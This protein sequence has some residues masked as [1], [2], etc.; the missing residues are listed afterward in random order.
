MNVKTSKNHDE[1]YQIM[2]KNYDNCRENVKYLKMA[3]KPNFK[4]RKYRE[5]TGYFHNLEI[6]LSSFKQAYTRSQK[7]P[8][9]DTLAKIVSSF[10]HYLD[11][12]I[13]KHL[14]VDSLFEAPSKFKERFPKSKISE[15]YKERNLRTEFYIE[16]F[17]RIYYTVFN[18]HEEAYYG[19]FKIFEKNGTYSARLLKGLQSENDEQIKE[20]RGLFQKNNPEKISETF[21]A[22]TNKNELTKKKT[23]EACHLYE[24]DHKKIKITSECITIEFESTDQC[25]IFM[26]WNTEISN[27]YSGLNSYIGGS[28]ML[29]ETNNGK[30]GKVIAS[31]KAGLEQPENLK[32]ALRDKGHSTDKKDKNPEETP[33]NIESM[34]LIDILSLESKN[35]WQVLDNADDSLWYRFLLEP[36]HRTK[37][38]I[39]YSPGEIQIIARQILK[40]EQEQKECIDR[41]KEF[42][43][44][45]ENLVNKLGKS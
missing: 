41:L 31:Y 11:S 4:E 12:D 36:K 3:I 14:T 16:K 2:E 13:Y 32:R 27:R 24:A 7:E 17:F 35:G 21:K 42:E 39:S 28:V 18:T 25:R 30:R 19:F 5:E 44:K 20:L 33:L 10:S 1:R 15:G 22:M 40:M 9:D 43:E 26:I 34:D 23:I 37:R 45:L 29:V 8:S 38:D 6:S